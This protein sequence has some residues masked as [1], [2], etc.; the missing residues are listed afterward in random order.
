[1]DDPFIILCIESTSEHGS[2]DHEFIQKIGVIGT[3]EQGINLI[4][5]FFAVK[6]H[7][8]MLGNPHIKWAWSEGSLKKIMSR[9]VFRLLLKHFQFVKG[10]VLLAKIIQPTIPYRI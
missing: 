7:L 5:G 4:R 9:E 2:N 1:M 10:C 8:K 3:D 6:W